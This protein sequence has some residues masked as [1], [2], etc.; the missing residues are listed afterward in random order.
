M[1]E[2]SIRK[3]GNTLRALQFYRLSG[4]FAPKDNIRIAY[5]HHVFTKDLANFE[6]NINFL[7]SDREAVTPQ[8]FF[9]FYRVGAWKG[10]FILFTFDDGLLSSYYAAKHILGKYKIKAIFFVPTKILELDSKEEMKRFVA[11]QVYFNERDIDTLHQEEYL[12]MSRDNLIEL[13]KE[14]HLI[15]P[16]TH[17]HCRLNQITD[18]EGVENQI[19][20]PKRVLEDLLGSKIEAFAFPVGTERAVSSYSYSYVKKEYRFCFTGLAGTNSARTNKHFLH[21]DC[22]HAHFDLDYI[23]NVSGGVYDLYYLY[24]MRVLKKRAG[25]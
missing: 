15:L 1:E 23:R 10:R 17:S 9:E 8:E 13:H 24:K 5:T 4:L 19:I 16:H 2:D 6:R 20:R 14:G 25:S 3:I 22:F 7:L 18:K 11:S 21:R 12:T